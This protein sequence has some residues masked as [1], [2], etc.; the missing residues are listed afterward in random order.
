VPRLLA[1]IMHYLTAE[2]LE[3]AGEQKLGKRKRI[4]S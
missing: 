4:T 1:A 3:I 2:I